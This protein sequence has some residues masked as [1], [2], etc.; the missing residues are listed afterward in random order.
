[1][2]ISNGSASKQREVSAPSLVAT[3]AVRFPPTSWRSAN[4]TSQKVTKYDEKLCY[5]WMTESEQNISLRNKNLNFSLIKIFLGSIEGL[6]YLS[7]LHVTFWN[8][9]N[10]Y[11][12]WSWIYRWF[13]ILQSSLISQKNLAHWGKPTLRFTW[14]NLQPVL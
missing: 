1:M 3:S 8:W 9:L 14:T 10:Q 11:M 5:D 12:F 13:L 7:T 4:A 2:S 6:R